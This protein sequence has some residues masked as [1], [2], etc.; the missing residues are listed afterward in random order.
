MAKTL[1]SAIPS[2]DMDAEQLKLSYI[3]DGNANY[4]SHFEKKFRSILKITGKQ[5]FDWTLQ[6]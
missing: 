3:V 5:C 6:G 2:V 4:N 1:K